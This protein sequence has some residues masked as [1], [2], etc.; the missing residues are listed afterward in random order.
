MPAGPVL[1]PALPP[2][3][4]LSAMI[5]LGLRI[6]IARGWGPMIVFLYAF[7]F[8]GPK[9]LHTLYRQLGPTFQILTQSPQVPSSP[10]PRRIEIAKSCAPQKT[11]N[12]H[13]D[14][15]VRARERP[16]RR[17]AEEKERAV[18]WEQRLVTDVRRFPLSSSSSP[19]ATP[20]TH[21]RSQEETARGFCPNR[22]RPRPV[23]VVDFAAADGI[24]AAASATDPTFVPSVP[25]TGNAKHQRART[26]DMW[27]L[28]I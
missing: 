12:P 4:R 17:S 19:V 2:P 20:R 28:R 16:R 22:V 3:R 7:P 10:T 5:G 18:L 15:T 21:G 8:L 24:Q 25:D 27:C 26:M 23:P 13:T 9:L 1:A 14:E 11:P 6:A